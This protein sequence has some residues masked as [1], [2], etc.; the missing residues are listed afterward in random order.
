MQ[1]WL[2]SKDPRKL[3]KIRGRVGGQY[4]SVIA[5]L[6]DNF[7]FTVGSE[8]STPF[9]VSLPAGAIQKAAFVANISQK[10]G[11]RMRKM[12][13]NPE[14]VE[15]SFEM[16]FVSFYSARDEV[17]IPILNLTSMSLGTQ[18]ND[19]EL[20]RR[21]R[22]AAA[23]VSSFFNEATQELSIDDQVQNALGRQR[24]L[25]ESIR[26]GTPLRR[27]NGERERSDIEN[28]SRDAFNWVAERVGI[29]LGPETQTLNFGN[30]ISIPNVYITSIAPQFSNTLDVEGI[31][32]SAKVNVTCTLELYPTAEDVAGWFSNR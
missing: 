6:P 30:F 31:P 15:I 7:G 24:S 29:I 1:T 14:P 10:I 2:E 22:E 9:D 8:F 20:E 23:G 3:I 4:R 19:E 12:Y 28:R 21:I 13:S 17:L 26:N 5:P 11:V 25:E 18:L 16:E 32:V 27:E